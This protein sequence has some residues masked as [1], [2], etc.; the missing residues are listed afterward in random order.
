MSHI[1][2]PVWIED[3]QGLNLKGLARW[4]RMAWDHPKDGNRKPLRDC[5]ISHLQG[6]RNSKSL[7]WGSDGLFEGLI[8]EGI[9][10]AVGQGSVVERFL[11]IHEGSISSAAKD[12]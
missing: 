12:Y 6:K 3:G 1:S 2:Q 9:I 7:S 11:S 4:L 8:L 10:R 5:V